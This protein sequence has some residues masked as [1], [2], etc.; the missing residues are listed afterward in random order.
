MN[1]ERNAKTIDFVFVSIIIIFSRQHF[2]SSMG[3]HAG[4]SGTISNVE[5]TE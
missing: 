3:V 5:N 1:F 2:S 4:I